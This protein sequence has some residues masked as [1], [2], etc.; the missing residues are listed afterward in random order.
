M[1]KEI[2]LKKSRNEKK[3]EAAEYFELQGIKTGFI[4]MSVMYAVISV[5]NLVF[6]FLKG[7]E[8][9]G[10]YVASAMYFCFSASAGRQKYKFTQ[11]KSARWQYISSMITAVIFFI[12]WAVRILWP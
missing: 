4:W 2:I 5:S 11:S 8:M 3:D 12:N 7:G 6:V 10:F 9:L 1:N